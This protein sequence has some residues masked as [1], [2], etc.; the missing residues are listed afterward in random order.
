MSISLVGDPVEETSLTDAERFRQL[1]DRCNAVFGA[2]LR[3]NL[4]NS[5]KTVDEDKERKVQRQIA[6]LYA[7][8]EPLAAHGSYATRYKGPLCKEALRRLFD[9]EFIIREDGENNFFVSW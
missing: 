6:K 2:Q 4:G 5:R 8:C 9:R 3:E 7:F 1:A